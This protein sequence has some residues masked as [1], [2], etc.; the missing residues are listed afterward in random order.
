[1]KKSFLLVGLLTAMTV[2]AAGC[3]DPDAVEDIEGADWRTTRSF[4]YL[5]WNTPDG[6]EDLL[7]H[8]YEEYGVVILAPDQEDYDPF[9]DCELTDGIHSSDI[10]EDSMTMKDVNG[11]G[12]D[13]FCVD[14]KIGGEIVTEVFLYNQE[15]NS[16]EYSEQ[17]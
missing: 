5:E 8:G 17:N 4:V 1:M 11:D 12:Y 10:V 2:F 16:F 7:A 15:N 9:P 14:D 3:A 13:D 6:T